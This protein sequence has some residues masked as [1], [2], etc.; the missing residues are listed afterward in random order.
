ML[1]LTCSISLEEEECGGENNTVPLVSVRVFVI[2]FSVAAFL[3]CHTCG[4]GVASSQ[5]AASDVPVYKVL[6]WAKPLDYSIKGT[7]GGL[8]LLTL[9]IL[10]YKYFFGRVCNIDKDGFPTS[11]S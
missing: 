4:K 2:K 8:A 11:V 7:L 9:L 1:N 5:L 3:S 10:Y 6:S